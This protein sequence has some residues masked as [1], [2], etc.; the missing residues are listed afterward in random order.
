[1]EK[2]TCQQRD[3]KDGGAAESQPPKMS[4]FESRDLWTCHLMGQRG[5]CRWG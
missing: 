5:L 3:P 1:M 4:T 2:V